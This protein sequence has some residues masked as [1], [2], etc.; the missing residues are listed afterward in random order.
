MKKLICVLCTLVM[1]LLPVLV[2]AEGT[3]VREWKDMGTAHL[4]DFSIEVWKDD[5]SAGIL[6][7]TYVMLAI[8]GEGL[9]TDPN[10][11]LSLNNVYVGEVENKIYIFEPFPVIDDK[12]AVVIELDYTE[13]TWR[14]LLMEVE[15]SDNL[16]LICEEYCG[17]NYWPVSSDAI[18]NGFYTIFD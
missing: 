11:S 12:T 7:T 6:A 4:E 15:N 18:L 5:E 8:G 2:M 16:D 3:D 1:A 13:N 17:Q 14:Y 10:L 9:L